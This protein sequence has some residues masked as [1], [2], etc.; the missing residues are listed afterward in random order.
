MPNVHPYWIVSMNLLTLVPSRLCEQID[1]NEFQ[2]I[3]MDV[4]QPYNIKKKKKT[5]EK[6]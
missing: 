3:Y 5:N 4:V 6:S 2:K 1:K